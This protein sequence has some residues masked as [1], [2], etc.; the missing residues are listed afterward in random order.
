MYMLRR[1]RERVMALLDELRVGERKELMG[2]L[3]EWFSGKLGDVEEEL[4]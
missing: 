1:R 3:D 2:K 4:Y